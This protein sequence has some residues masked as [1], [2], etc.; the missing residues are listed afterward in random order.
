MHNHAAVCNSDNR[1]VQWLKCFIASGIP[2]ICLYCM[3]L[4]HLGN[5]QSKY[6]SVKN[7]RLQFRRT[8][9]SIV[10]LIIPTNKCA[11]IALEAVQLG[12]VLGVA[13]YVEMPQYIH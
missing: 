4:M 3:R 12:T 7:N 9:F 6:Q 2:K 11:P 5:W 10:L 8:G 1:H 13:S